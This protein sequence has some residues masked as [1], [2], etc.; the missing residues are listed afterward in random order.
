MH[1]LCGGPRGVPDLPVSEVR[2]VRDIRAWAAGQHGVIARWQ[3]L[4][5]DVPARRID[6]FARRWPALQR[7]VHLLGNGPSWHA[8]LLAA[9]LACGPRPGVAVGVRSGAELRGLRDGGRRAIDLVVARGDPHPGGVRVL[10][11]V[12]LRAADVSFVDGIPCTTVARTL[13]DC[14]ALFGEDELRTMANAAR[15]LGT[16]DV[17]ACEAQLVRHRGHAGTAALRRLVA[18]MPDP[19][20]SRLEDHFLALL[21]RAG[22]DAGVQVNHRHDAAGRWVRTDFRWPHAA[23]VVE[24]KGFSVHG[25]RAA[26]HDDADR[27]LHLREA[28]WEVLSF[29]WPQVRDTPARLARLVGRELKG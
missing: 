29:T 19:T 18:L 3:L 11:S 10:T 14:A 24:V 13:L 28:G 7:G 15:R 4:A 16:L 8:R 25:D 9:V 1:A 23:L 12:D 26:F 27:D 21:R 2:E 20:E 17:A 5:A 6:S 22:L